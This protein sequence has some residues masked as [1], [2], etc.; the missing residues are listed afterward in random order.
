[1]PFAAPVL[2]S[3]F[4]SFAATATVAEDERYNFPAR[5]ADLPSGVYFWIGGPHAGG[6]Q[7]PKDV[8]AARFDED[9]AEWTRTDGPTPEHGNHL[10]YGMPLYAPVSGEIVT[11]WRNSPESILPAD[12]PDFPGQF[13]TAGNRVN[14]LT[15]AG[16]VA[17][18]AH[19][20]PDSLPE[21]LCPNED[22]L[23]PVGFPRTGPYP[24]AYVL[25]P[26]TRPRVR[27]G[28]LI[29]RLGDSG[30]SGGP[31]LHYHLKDAEGGFVT[32][33]GE[34]TAREY[35]LSYAWVQSTSTSTALDPDAWV[36][37]AQ[38]AHHA[39]PRLLIWPDLLLRR[40]HADLD[41]G[42]ERDLVSH[43]DHVVEAYADEDG[44]L[45][46]AGYRVGE[47][48]LTAID[49]VTGGAAAQTRIAQIGVSH[50]FVVGLRAAN[51]RL[52]LIAVDMTASGN[53]DR[54]GEFNG[55]PI[56]HLQMASLAPAGFG[57]GFVTAARRPDGTLVL[58]SWSASGLGDDAREKI[59]TWRREYNEVRPHG[60]IG[61]RPPIATLSW[62]ETTSP[63]A[64]PPE[65][66]PRVVQITGW[67]QEP[68]NSSFRRSKVGE[69]SA[70]SDDQF[71]TRI[72]TSGRQRLSCAGG[73]AC[74]VKLPAIRP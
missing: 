7:A 24:S 59:E 25:D 6:N 47:D 45:R 21:A 69:Q 46:V 50:D 29:G 41:G 19:L 12:N 74:A 32:S 39:A 37:A 1:M 73:F 4:L 54:Q 66:S 18:V 3:V 28:Q 51:N 5:A 68:E 48:G 22:D 34:S 27:R 16:A 26:A 38:A 57:T 72:A 61:D 14:I 13:T 62:L 30:N 23:L 44:D 71:S 56:T 60:A 10:A 2:A 63:A 58:D 64:K 36:P 11:C 55:D 31:H 43:L 20:L 40:L 65:F 67:D 53:L 35:P 70:R 52:K 17:L 33:F 15:E 9:A 8:V 49:A 42:A